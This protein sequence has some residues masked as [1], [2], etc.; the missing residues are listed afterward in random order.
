MGGWRWVLI[1]A[2]FGAA[3]TGA[4][5]VSALP[6]PTGAGIERGVVAVQCFRDGAFSDGRAA[7]LDVGTDV[8]DVLLTTAHTLLPDADA[9]KRDCRVLVRGQPQNIAAV[10]HAGGNLLAVEQDWAVILTARIPG[11]VRRWRAA[12][13][14]GEWLTNAAAHG[15]PVRLVMRYAD[16]P[17]TD[18]RLE[19]QTPNPALLFAH[20]CVTYAGLSGSPLVVA[21]EGESEPVVIGI[22]VGVQAYWRRQ[23][24]DFVHIARAVDPDVVAAIAAAEQR[25]ALAQAASVPQGRRGVAR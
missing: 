24:L 21:I 8:A 14:T 12:N 4:D 10:W 1:A 15:A 9:I 11:D 17:Q 6:P 23:R 19:P 18:C 25:A 5:E 16:A 2:G 20:S 22:H 13:V 3:P 7:I